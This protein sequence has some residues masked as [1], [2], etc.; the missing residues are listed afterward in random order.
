MVSRYCYVLLLL[1]YN[2]LFDGEK[3]VLLQNFDF[4]GNINEYIQKFSERVCRIYPNFILQTSTIQ[5]FSAIAAQGNKDQHVEG[6][7]IK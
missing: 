4:D 3:K 2:S 5:N 7:N 6:P 1:F